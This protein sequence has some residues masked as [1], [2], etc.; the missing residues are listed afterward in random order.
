LRPPL[1]T[2]KSF[3]LGPTLVAGGANFSV[4][5]KHA[6]AVQLLLFD[7]AD[8]ERPAKV[9]DLDPGTQRT[10]H[11]W[12]TFV[13]DMRAGQLYGYRAR[14]PYAPEK[15]LRFDA[16][17]VLLD[18]YGRCVARPSRVSRAGASAPGGNAATALKSVLTDPLAYDWGDDRPPRTPFAKTI[19]YEV[20]VGNFTR[21]PNS[22]VGSGRRGTFAGL[23]E[24][25]PYLQDLGVTALELLPVF[26][27]DEESAPQG[28]RNVWGY[29]PVS[30]FAPHPG[31]SSRR[32][33][34]GALNE[35][36]DLVKAAHR[37]GIEII[38]DV[39]YN[40]TAEGSADG[41]TINLRGLANDT[42]Y[43]LDKNG[44]GYADYSGTGNSLNANESIVRR[45]VLDSLRYWV[46]E[47]H[48]DGFRF[49]LAAVLSRDGRGRPTTSPPVLLDIE[50]DPILANVKLIAEAWD[51]AGLY[52][53]GHFFGDAWK[54]WN[55][56]FRDDVRRFLKGDEGTVRPLAARILGSP[57]IYG[58]QG[59]EPE[60]S[61]NF[62]TCHDGFTLNDLVSYNH[63]HNEAN[64]EENRDG[65]DGNYSWNCGVEGPSLDDAIE[66]L[67]NR[68][69][70]NF[71]TLT[72]FATG[73][74]ML[75][76]GDEIRRTQRGNN[77]AYC[78]DDET[79]WFDWSAIA[80]H[81][82]IHRFVK[83]LIAFRQA[84]TLS[85]ER[86]GVTLNELIAQHR[87]E[88]HGIALG[89][90]D[91][92][93]ASHSLAETFHVDGDGLALHWMFN[94]YW[95]P[96]E[97]AIPLLDQSFVPWRR[98]VDT[99]RPAPGDVSTWANA[100]T[101]HG[102][103]CVVQPRSIV[104]LVTEYNGADIPIAFK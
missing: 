68:Q 74:P 56:R 32:D 18:P 89:E 2:G 14:G 27:F 7:G 97:F 102:P 29:Q 59:R 21:H 99:F 81:A 83:Q 3:P 84:R 35:F 82:D 6:S 25:I 22:G 1:E 4:F 86:L 31:Y 79:T 58:A 66:R 100:E 49:D 76:M 54:E 69:V 28:R 20:H 23:I 71:L 30:F 91:W 48:V 51:A 92:S 93:D 46:V 60:Q 19:I 103:T 41:P 72:L 10:Y 15:G 16:D 87:V 65:S 8:D 61:I 12:H 57:D 24:K 90:P 67:R 36:R 5:S 26:A 44:A 45:L 33:P 62:V 39:V 95:E 40:H 9:I 85:L 96:L 63:K 101:V 13:P 34:L 94:A 98:V 43:I 50:S 11:Y 80:R 104:V 77:N 38:L 17:K 70:K 53:V 42:Y 64:G 52:E 88:W 73:T 78:I 37:A 47:M 75:L 55:G